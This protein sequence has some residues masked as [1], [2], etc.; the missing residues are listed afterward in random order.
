MGRM[1]S[2]AFAYCSRAR[3]G[4]GSAWRRQRATTEDLLPKDEDR[5]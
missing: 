5:K 1:V 2:F 4:A 3:A